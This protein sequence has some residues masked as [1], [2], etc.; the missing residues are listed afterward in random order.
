MG[1]V[2]SD[3]FV[4]ILANV[5]NLE[6]LTPQQLRFIVNLSKRIQNLES[7]LVVLQA[8]MVKID[9]ELTATLVK[10]FKH[11]NLN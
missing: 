7:K 6:G 1:N 11:I 4:S 10:S 8:R 5:M 9:P 2:G 3:T